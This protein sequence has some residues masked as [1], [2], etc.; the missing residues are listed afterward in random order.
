MRALLAGLT[1][2]QVET[3]SSRLVQLLISTASWLERVRTV[4]LFGGLKSEPD[5]LPL[6]DWL[7][8]NGRQVVYF[9]VGEEGVMHPHR[10]RHAGELVTGVHGVLMPDVFR[11]PRVDEADLDVVLVPG[12]AFSV[13][14][15]ARLGRGKGYYDRVLAQLRPDA[16]L[17]GVGFLEQMIESIPCEP[18]DRRVH[19][20]VTEDGWR[21]PSQ[22]GSSI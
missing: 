10:V 7:S 3:R 22:A 12:L 8:E 14:D 16:R 6:L 2:R 1:P 15:G 13:R 4:A 18:H 9:F 21:T 5:L 11:C 20:L 17:I 19:S